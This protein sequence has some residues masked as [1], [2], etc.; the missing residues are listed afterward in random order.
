MTAVSK[1]GKL[2]LLVNMVKHECLRTLLDSTIKN[3]NDYDYVYSNLPEAD[4]IPSC[5]NKQVPYIFFCGLE[6]KSGQV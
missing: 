5:K 1:E 2:L 4:L 3:V 6:S